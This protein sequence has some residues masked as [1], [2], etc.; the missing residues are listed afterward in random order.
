MRGLLGRDMFCLEVNRRV[1]Y[2]GKREAIVDSTESEAD[3][4]ATLCA[5][6]G[7]QTILFL[8]AIAIE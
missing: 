4:D 5:G 8:I 6:L 7:E 3:G 1:I 2:D